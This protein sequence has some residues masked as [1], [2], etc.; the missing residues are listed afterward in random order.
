LDYSIYLFGMPS[1]LFTMG[2]KISSLENIFHVA[3][4]WNFYSSLG[5]KI[6]YVYPS[7]V[8]EDLDQ[9]ST[10]NHNEKYFRPSK[11]RYKFINNLYFIRRYLVGLFRKL[12][13]KIKLKILENK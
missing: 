13:L 1:F 5:L 3:D 12:L 6:G 9:K 11:S 10:L 8:I 7:I 2:G 4:D